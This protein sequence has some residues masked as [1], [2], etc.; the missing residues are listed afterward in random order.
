MAWE[1]DIVGPYKS[2]S[3]CSE[4]NGSSIVLAFVLRGMEVL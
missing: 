1:T 3:F 4:G 2:F